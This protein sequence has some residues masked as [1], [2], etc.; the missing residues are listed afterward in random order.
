MNNNTEQSFIYQ[1]R[2]TRRAGVFDMVNAPALS[3][4]ASVLNNTTSTTTERNAA[5]RQLASLKTRIGTV[6]LSGLKVDRATCRA[7]T[8]N[9]TLLRGARVSNATFEGPLVDVN[10]QDAWGGGLAL[11]GETTRLNLNG[12]NVWDFYANSLNDAQMMNSVFASGRINTMSGANAHSALMADVNIGDAQNAKFVE[13]DM[14]F[15]AV[16]GLN[17]AVVK[18]SVAPNM[19]GAPQRYAMLSDYAAAMSVKQGADM[20]AVAQIG[21]V[22]LTLQPEPVTHQ[23]AAFVARRRTPVMGIGIAA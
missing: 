2:R 13:T 6:N 5:L 1:P 8:R 12:A 7:L 11:L 4:A 3:D 17:N 20:T 15:S 18:P 21:D 9:Q 14:T 10:M 23:K 19:T 22:N 16:G